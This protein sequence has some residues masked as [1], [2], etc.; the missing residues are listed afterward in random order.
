MTKKKKAPAH[1]TLSGLEVNPI[2]TYVEEVINKIL[3]KRDD[4]LKE[5]D[6]KQIIKAILPEI[7]KI[8][9]KIVLKHFKSIA[10]YVQANLKDPEGK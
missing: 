7:E 1:A 8:V 5:E 4:K 6:A 3:N 9:A 2:E 10:V